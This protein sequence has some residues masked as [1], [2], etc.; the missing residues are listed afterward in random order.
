MALVDFTLA[1]CGI[2]TATVPIDESDIDAEGNPDPDATFEGPITVTIDGPGAAEALIWRGD[3]GPDSGRNPWR[4]SVSQYPDGLTAGDSPLVIA[5][6][7]P[8]KKLSD[9]SWSL[10]FWGG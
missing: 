4:T 5:T 9:V 7:G 2:V 10:S 3:D 6:G 8:V 1:R